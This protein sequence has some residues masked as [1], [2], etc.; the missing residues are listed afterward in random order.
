MCVCV[1]GGWEVS[2]GRLLPSIPLGAAVGQAG[3]LAA[4][5]PPQARLW[6]KAEAPCRAVT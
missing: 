5:A 6:L 3:P 2:R 1:G 4:G